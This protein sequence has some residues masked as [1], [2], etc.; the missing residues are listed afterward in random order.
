MPYSTVEDLRKLLPEEVLIQLTDDEALEAVNTGRAQEAIQQ[1]DAVI[2]A[3]LGAR[4]QVPLAEPVPEL[5][6]KLS[7]DMAIYH[8]Y[9][10]RTEEMPEL[11]RQR[12]RDALKTLK[13]I[14]QG[15]ISLG[16]QEPNPSREDGPQV[17]TS[18]QDRTFTKDTLEGY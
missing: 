6:K 15:L 16:A 4:Y 8:L 18:E 12:Y 9:S 14:S 2:D 11:R 1:A 17:S 10:R 3:Y 7:V 13:D 5:I